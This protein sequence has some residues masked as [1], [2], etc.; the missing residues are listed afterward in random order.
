MTGEYTIGAAAAAAAVAAADLWVARTRVLADRRMPVV[1]ALILF[2]M[3]VANGW[4]TARPIVIY[5]DRY[6]ALP[7]L[8]TMPLED[9][10]YAFALVVLTLICWERAKRAAAATRSLREVD[11]DARVEKTS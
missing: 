3:L 5:D 4:L 1:G 6:R 2:F 10:L 9:L 8:G 7:R 11:T